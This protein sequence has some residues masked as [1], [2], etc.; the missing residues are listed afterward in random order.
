[1]KDTL[2]NFRRDSI[3]RVIIEYDGHEDEGFVQKVVTI[4]K[5][6][7]KRETAGMDLFHQS[8]Q[9]TAPGSHAYRR[10]TSTSLGSVVDFVMKLLEENAAGWE[11]GEGGFGTCIIDVDTGEYDLNHVWG[12]GSER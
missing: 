6:G 1:M 8:H 3:R 12:Y 2:D 4:A 5:D 10:S 9:E 7:T 11:T